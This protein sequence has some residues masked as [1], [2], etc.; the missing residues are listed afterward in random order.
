M[1]CLVHR[2]LLCAGKWLGGCSWKIG[3]LWFW[4]CGLWKNGLESEKCYS[5]SLGTIRA[6]VDSLLRVPAH[7]L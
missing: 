4:A 6:G 1:S 7:S 5:R 3:N 2:N